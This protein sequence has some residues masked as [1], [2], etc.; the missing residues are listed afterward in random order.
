MLAQ[1]LPESEWKLEALKEKLGSLHRCRGKVFQVPRRESSSNPLQWWRRGESE[2]TPALIPRSLLIGLRAKN[3]K[4]TG[5]AQ[6]RY[7]A[8]GS[9][10]P[11]V[12]KAE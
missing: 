1:V 8:I 2:S 7:T 12:I 9:L 11:L 5:F 6:V 10:L 4:N 3:T